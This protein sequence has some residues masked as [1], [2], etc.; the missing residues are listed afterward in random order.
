LNLYFVRHGDAESKKPGQTDAEREL[1]A[2]GVQQAQELAKWMRE[3]GVQA[4]TV[5]TS[6]LAR[7]RQTAQPIADAL[8]VPMREDE[9]LSGGLLTA[10][11]LERI[12]KDAGDAES[13]ML[14]GHEP[15]LSGIIRELTGGEVEVKKAGAALVQC[16]GSRLAKCKLVW[17]IPA[18]LRD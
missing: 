6:P 13:I 7:A 4:A 18:A 14:V 16:D 12:I 9:H 11:A 8:G 10:G 15:D 1:T 2:V 3:H 5:I 17:L